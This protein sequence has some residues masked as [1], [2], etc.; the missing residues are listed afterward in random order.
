MAV[1]CQGKANRYRDRSLQRLQ[2]PVVLDG[3]VQRQPPATPGPRQRP[4]GLAP[5][6][7]VR[8]SC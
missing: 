1:E 5:G 2:R 6:E 3:L 8:L 4:P 7:G